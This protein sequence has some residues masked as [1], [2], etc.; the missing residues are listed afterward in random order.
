MSNVVVDADTRSK[1]L[2]AVGEVV[3]RDTDGRRLGRFIPDAVTP[4]DSGITEEEL[5]R[6]AADTAPGHTPDAVMARL[7]C[8][9]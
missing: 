2:S 6:R 7:R 8:L 3:V 9:S 1:L 4:L 5:L